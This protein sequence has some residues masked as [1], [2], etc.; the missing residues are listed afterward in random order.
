MSKASASVSDF[1]PAEH[2]S[3]SSKKERLVSKFRS[4]RTREAWLGEYDWGLLFRP[5]FKPWSKN[6][7]TISKSE[8]PFYG[9]EDDLPIVLAAMAG[10]QHAL[11]ML[12]GLIT[13]P[14]I[15]GQT[16]NLPSEQRSYL[17]SASLIA[18]G[19]LSAIQMSRIPLFG[20]YQLGTGVLSVVGT[21]FATLSTAQ[22]IIAKLYANGTCQ[23]IDGVQ[24]ACPEAYGYILGTSALCALL[25]MGLSFVPIRFL[26]RALPPIITGPV[27]FL[28]GVS[29]IQSSG[30]ANWGGGAGCGPE[31]RSACFDPHGYQWGS[32][33]YIGLGFLSWLTVIVIEIFGSPSM[34]NASIVLGLLIPL[35]VAGPTGY[36]SGDSIKSAKP[37][38]FLW[39]HTFP[40]KI[41]APAI[42]PLLAV[43]LSLVAEAIG[44]ITATSEVS[45]LSVTSKAYDRR[46]QGGIL[47]D[48]LG[49]LLSSLFTI[50]PLSVFAQN[51]AVISITS[52]ANRRAGYWCC[53][54]LI[55]FGVLGKIAGAIL[56]IPASILGGVTT[57]LFASVAVSGLKV[58]STVTFTRR[59]RFLLALS[60][61]IGVGNLLVPTW[62]S[63]IFTYPEN[64]PNGALRGFL[65]SIEIVVETPFL[66][67]AV[68]GI[69]A[70]FILPLE[71]EDWDVFRLKEE[72]ERQEDMEEGQGSKESKGPSAS[73]A[74]P[75]MTAT[76]PELQKAPNVDD[77]TDITEHR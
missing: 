37:I 64:G 10:L 29:L 4:L 45:R 5:R 56:A 68:V 20:G 28:I 55:L 6:I 9:L 59:S 57:I 36:I 24:Q 35:V 43:Y 75:T 25:P 77:R 2:T 70:N 39:V 52:I 40:L 66:I 47:S 22:A 31:P 17:I 74:Q 41:Y 69:I 32:G 71:L 26:K 50:T 12:A 73:S 21:S 23:T 13:P 61:G 46:L 62:F 51:N 15:L 63:Y 33:R 53:A 49:G 44:D 42:L 18:C 3:S 7:D 38:T 67:C 72:A 16:L 11:A 14:Q 30:F 8:A 54:W 34:R 58:I 1:S 27:V 60:L 65:D 19:F 76:A 48:G